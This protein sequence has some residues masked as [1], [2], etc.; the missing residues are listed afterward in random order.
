MATIWHRF[1]F[2]ALAAVK[3]KARDIQIRETCDGF[4]GSE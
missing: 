2:R 4:K 1:E 3:L